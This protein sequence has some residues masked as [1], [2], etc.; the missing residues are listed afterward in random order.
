[1]IL[2]VVLLQK[3]LPAETLLSMPS[4]DPNKALPMDSQLEQP[5]LSDAMPSTEP[6]RQKSVRNPAAPI[7]IGLSILTGL[8]VLSVFQWSTVNQ[9]EASAALG[10]VQSV[11]QTI[12][13]FNPVHFTG[14]RWI[15]AKGLDKPYLSMH[16][17]LL[18][19]CLQAP[20]RQQRKLLLAWARNP[21]HLCL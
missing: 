8:V 3:T 12:L 1:V 11:L 14:A 9:L 10:D 18:A 6:S 21:Q 20:M 4:S 2:H 17:Q 5:L 19:F 13:A 7:A 16:H 15:V